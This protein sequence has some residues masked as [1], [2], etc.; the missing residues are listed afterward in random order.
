MIVDIY[1][2]KSRSDEELEKTL[3]NGETLARHRKALLRYAKENKYT[4]LNI[5]EE[6]V[7]GEELFFR[8]AMLATLKDVESG[9][10][11]GVLVMDIQRLG[12]GDMEEQ[13]LILKAFKKSNTKIITPKKIYDLNDEFD[14]E[15][16]EFEAF[17]SR[18]EYK[19][20]N[21]RMQRGRINSVEEGNYIA[22]RPP[23]GY[24]I[25]RIDKNTRTLIPNTE[26]VEVVK[27]IFNWY[28]NENM[29]CSKI[30]NELNQLGIKSYT[31]AL[32]EKSTIANFFKNPVYIGK[33]VW[34]KKCIR[35]S[36]EYGKKRET[37]T[38]P[39]EEW[40]I[41][42]GKHKSIIEESMY[43]KAQTLLAQ[44]YHVPYPIKNSITNPL[45]G[46]VICGIC[47]CKMVQRNV[48][49]K[50]SRII[51][52]KNCGQKSNKITTVENLLVDKLE[53]Y[54]SNMLLNAK[55]N[56]QK[57]DPSKSQLIEKN[58]SI[59]KNE[60]ITLKKQKNKAFNLLEQ[61]VYDIGTFTERSN[62]IAERI[63]QI[64][65]AVSESNKQLKEAQLAYSISRN[66][67]D[68]I[69]KLRNVLDA[70]KK[71]ESS[72]DKNILMK[73]ILD[74]VVY[75]K[76]PDAKSDDFTITLYPKIAYNSEL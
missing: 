56:L 53:S 5:H 48:V 25:L 55:K 30:A 75:N 17:M 32:W 36:K 62:Y 11:D 57:T 3:G 31:G 58:I 72:L 74:K 10:C 63:N 45:A 43:Q 35:K 13:G 24:D 1:L 71:I 76:L 60:L 28:V 47:G 41:C 21:R 42:N 37:Y 33:V 9:A 19:M 6:L 18:K 52:P 34:K 54:Y 50:D 38:R 69:I 27:M 4:I 16:S 51:C 23:Y 70:Y 68:Y 59:L 67:Q 66:Y 49:N 39:A 8:P 26:Q 7:S 64:N 12:R 29:G 46:V 44:K 61:G 20:I 14:E 73:S 15:Y 2:R 40:I 22:T 65:K